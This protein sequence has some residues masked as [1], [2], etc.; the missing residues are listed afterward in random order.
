MIIIDCKN[1]KLE[2]VLKE[3]RQKVEKIGQIHE[4]RERLTYEKPSI[5]RR[6]EKKFA[7]YRNKKYGS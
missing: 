2:Q 5:R 6:K 4:L 7:Q 1:R 3:Y